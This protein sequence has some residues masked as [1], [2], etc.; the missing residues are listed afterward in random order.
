AGGRGVRADPGGG[1][2]WI[3]DR[4]SAAGGEIV[5]GSDPCA[6]PKA[7]K[8]AVEIDGTRAAHRRDGAAVTRFL[9]W[10]ADHAST[11]RL[12]EIEAAERLAAVRRENDPLRDLSLHTVSGRRPKRRT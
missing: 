11:G 6:L 8:N 1:A 7:C 5:R 2:A 10:L 4:L 9:A 3:F 12:T